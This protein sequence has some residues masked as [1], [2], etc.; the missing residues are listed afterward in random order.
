MNSLLVSYLSTFLFE[1]APLFTCRNKILFCTQ[2][3]ASVLIKQA[4]NIY[5]RNMCAHTNLYKCLDYIIKVIK[6]NQP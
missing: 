3:L 5:E 6:Q 1:L 4:E 2:R